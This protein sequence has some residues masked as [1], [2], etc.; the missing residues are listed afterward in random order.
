MQVI[1]EDLRDYKFPAW[2]QDAPAESC[3]T[4]DVQEKVITIIAKK[5]E[6][7][8]TIT[9]TPDAKLSDFGDSLTKI[10]L[11][12]EIEQAFGLDITP[13]A[14]LKKMLTVEDVAVYVQEAIKPCAAQ[15][16]S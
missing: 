12:C 9:V 6:D 7:D 15:A 14:A 1:D 3:M 10:D 5:L 11:L 4:M 13:D 16:S 8:P 2:A